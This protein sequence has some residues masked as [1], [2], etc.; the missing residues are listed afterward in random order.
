MTKLLEEAIEAVRR[1]P[2]ERQDV[3]ASAMLAAAEEAPDVDRTALD[4]AID[5]GIADADVGRFASDEEIKR[6]FDRLRAA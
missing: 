2:R 5:E 6:L 3:V 1:L 4:A